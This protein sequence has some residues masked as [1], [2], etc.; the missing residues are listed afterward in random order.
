MKISETTL[1]KIIKSIGMIKEE[2]IGCDTCFEEL[3]RFVDM[4]REGKD[5]AQVLP[6]VQNHLEICPCCQ[7]E[8]EALLN[9]LAAIDEDIS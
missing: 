7:E 3:D 5:P 2:E 1:K 9:A 4:L 6:L 8:T